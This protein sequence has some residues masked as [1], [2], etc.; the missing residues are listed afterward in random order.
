MGNPDRYLIEEALRQKEFPDE[1]AEEQIS[2]HDQG[3]VMDGDEDSD[4]EDILFYVNGDEEKVDNAQLGEGEEDGPT[5]APEKE[6]PARVEKVPIHTFQQGLVTYATP[7]KKT[8][9][10]KVLTFTPLLKP[11]KELF[12]TIRN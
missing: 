1:I 8:I 9:L 10:I 2:D 7:T 4:D 6:V 12:K 11:R 3:E 5:L